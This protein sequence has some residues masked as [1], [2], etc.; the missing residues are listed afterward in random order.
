MKTDK[1]CNVFLL[2]ERNTGKKQRRFCIF[3]PLPG[4]LRKGNQHFRIFQISAL[5]PSRAETQDFG[6]P[7]L[8]FW[9]FQGDGTRIQGS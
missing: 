2:I 7:M 5:G 4:I 1:I 3:E 9:K 8:D 6:M